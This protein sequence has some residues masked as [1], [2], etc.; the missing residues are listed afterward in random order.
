M[1]KMDNLNMG[2]KDNSTEKDKIEEETQRELSC[3][4]KLSHVPYK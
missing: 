4:E 3:L 2:G 1:L